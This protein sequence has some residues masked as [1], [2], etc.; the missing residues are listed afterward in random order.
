MRRYVRWGAGRL[1]YR[2]D[3]RELDHLQ[4]RCRCEF[5][6]R[7][8]CRRDG[9]PGGLHLLYRNDH[10][11]AE[12]D[13]D[14]G[15]QSIGTTTATAMLITE[16][17][18]GVVFQVV[19]TG[20]FTVYPCFVRVVNN[21]AGSIEVFAVV[22]GDSGSTGTATVETALPANNNDIVAA[23]T[24]LTN[25]GVT[26]PATGRASII[27]LA[28]N[29]TAFSQMMQQPGGTHRQHLLIAR[30]PAPPSGGAGSEQ[31]IQRGLR[32]PFLCPNAAPANLVRLPRR[33]LHCAPPAALG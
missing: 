31:R 20:N 1:V 10:H 27:L 14:P 24:I 23:T 15:G 25:A 4:R 8:Q 26:L 28:P 6:R 7:R 30:S 18:N 12:C 19:Y 21:T 33:L 9:Q 22:Q 32:P 5:E 11:R 13:S 3:L 2:D 29:G 17:Y 16:I